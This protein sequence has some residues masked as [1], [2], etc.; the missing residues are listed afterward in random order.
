MH[1]APSAPTHD[2]NLAP[3]RRSQ[4]SLLDAPAHPL[5]GGLLQR[6]ARDANGVAEG[7]DAAVEAASSSPGS[8]LPSEL[9]SQFEASLGTDLSPV[10]IHT[11]TASANAAAA[12]GAKAYTIGNDIH[13]GAGYCDASLLAGQQ[14]IAHEVVHTVQQQGGV[15]HRQDKLEVSPPGDA[16]ELEADRAADAMT[17]G[18]SV[19]LGTAFHDMCG[20]IHRQVTETSQEADAA[21]A[22]G[23]L[24]LVPD[25]S[26]SPGLQLSSPEWTLLGFASNSADVPSTAAPL[27]RRIA[28]DID[29][30][31]LGDSGYV[32]I[33][34][35]PDLGGAH[36]HDARLGQQR[37]DSVRTAIVAL[38]RHPEL[39]AQ[40]HTHSADEDV[41]TQAGDVAED[42][43]V[44]VTITRRTMHV[45]LDPTMHLTNPSPRPDLSLDLGPD[46]PRGVD[47]DILD[48]GRALGEMGRRRPDPPADRPGP[49]AGI[50]PWELS[51]LR[52]GGE[53]A[54]QATAS[55]AGLGPPPS[56]VYYETPSI[57]HHVGDGS[58]TVARDPADSLPSPLTERETRQGADAATAHD[59][60]V[61]APDSS[62]SPG[63][64]LSSPEWTLLG[65]ASN[66][67][68]VPSTAAPLIRRI[69][70][71]IDRN[72][73]GDS[74]YVV[75]WGYPDLGGAHSRDAR[76]GQQR[77]DSVRTAIVALL[78]HPEL[79]AQIHTH[80]ADEDVGTQAGDVAEDRQ[81][82]VTITRRTMHVPLDP[83]TH[84][85]D[86][87]LPLTDLSLHLGLD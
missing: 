39:A 52:P 41:G 3:G 79:A 68:D 53:L 30:N 75:I 13:F 67:A 43:Q 8:P 74:G 62:E 9:R 81:V 12:V 38:L 87:S 17:G 34:G 7:A 36:S 69:A 58:D 64:Q 65:F 55:S 66:S 51:V 73:L 26:E 80:S 48:V 61:L 85:T 59:P 70:E 27:I 44:T 21:T 40:I 78:H 35:Y 28:E 77:A 49:L 56:Q 23:P 29:H 72:G 14:L 24:V 20:V 71:D 60:L 18:A 25:S 16:A 50:D 32:V 45:P 47:D 86:P 1:G 15:P 37:A 83:T 42:R 22:H 6:K 33:W 46:H 31:G 82:T 2:D 57:P 84:L 63:L 5:A 11:G 19:E 4:S 10:R 54:A 76:L